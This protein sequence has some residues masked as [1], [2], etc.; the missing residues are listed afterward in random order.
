MSQPSS[1][2]SRKRNLYARCDQ[3]TSPCINDEEEDCRNIISSTPIDTSDVQTTSSTLQSI[4]RDRI[5]PRTPKC[6]RCR[7]HGVVSALKGHKRFCKW[8]DCN[9]AKCTLIA[10]RQRV[11]AAQVALR[12]QQA[13]EETE[14]R[15]ISKI[16]GTPAELVL[17]LQRTIGND[18]LPTSQSP[19]DQT[20]NEEQ[21]NIPSDDECQEQ[22]SPDTPSSSSNGFSSNSPEYSAEI[23]SNLH[24]AMTKLFP[25]YDNQFL[26]QF[27]RRSNGQLLDTL[28]N[29]CTIQKQNEMNDNQPSDI[30]RRNCASSE[31]QFIN[32]ILHIMSNWPGNNNFDLLQTT[33][34]TSDMENKSENN[35]S[36]FDNK[37]S[38]ESLSN[39]DK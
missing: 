3:T 28:R 8:R 20:F 32:N 38:I 11:M 29:M 18:N 21:S 10:E 17:S 6:A 37:F 33:L 19:S 5:P 27:I 23:N 1:D 7:N 35:K 22:Y 15:E 9:C 16:L 34:T 13:Q 36:K 31:T 12:R 4:L 14:I 26:L 2:R 30:K 39:N 25:Q 24:S